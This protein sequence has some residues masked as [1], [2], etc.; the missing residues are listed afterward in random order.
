[1]LGSS[2]IKNGLDVKYLR[3]PKG[4]IQLLRKK[5][6]NLASLKRKSHSSICPFQK[7]VTKLILRVSLKYLL[8]PYGSKKQ[9]STAK[10]LVKGFNFFKSGHVLYIGY[11]HKNGEHFIKSQVLPSMKKDKTYCHSRLP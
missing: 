1:M 2:N 8:E 4:G 5:K 11:L 6:L 7:K 9:L 3:D 10:P